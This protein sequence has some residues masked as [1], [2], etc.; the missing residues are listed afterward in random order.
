M[1]IEREEFNRHISRSVWKHFTK[2]SVVPYENKPDR[3][4]LLEVL[5][6]EINK[7]E[8]SP[9]AP[10]EYLDFNKGSGVLRIVPVFEIRDLAVYYFCVL[11][12]ED[13]IA[14]NRVEGTFGGYRMGN[15]I[16]EQEKIEIDDVLMEQVYPGVSI[17]PVAWRKSWTDYQKR[18][19][20]FHSTDNKYF[21]I[22]DIANFYDNINLRIL[23]NKIRR[24]IQGED[25]GSII[26]LLFLFLRNWNMQFNEYGQQIVGLPQDETGDSS[27]ILANFYLQDY[28]QRVKVLTES[29]GVGYLRFAD[30]QIFCAENEVKLENALYHSSIYLKKIGLNFNSQK[31]RVFNR[32][33][34]Y[35]FWSFDIF[36]LLE[37][38]FNKKRFVEA[39]EIYL[40]RE[41][42]KFN[43]LS[44]LR[45]FLNIVDFDALEESVKVPLISDLMSEDFIRKSDARYLK[46]LYKKL[47]GEYKEKLLEIFEQISNN[48]Q[49]KY[50]LYILRSLYEH[51]I[52]VLNIENI[53][54]KIEEKDFVKLFSS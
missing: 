22:V 15:P 2:Y 44:V 19:R 21:A 36:E 7:G 41:K 26:N 18:A 30:D 14:I 53:N 8:Y 23:E 42:K 29:E 48:Y 49:N 25:S 38:E 10:R 50:F 39:F 28:D 5:V 20:E 16:R 46:K 35:E 12:L 24:V 6:D 3:K 17:N 1:E 33:E 40:N 52:P 11:Q 27:R 34:F 47:P 4:E 32:N 9:S 45:R 54:N 51:D 13:Y 37:G 31:V 43:Q